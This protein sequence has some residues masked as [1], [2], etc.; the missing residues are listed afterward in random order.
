M[1]RNFKV[2]AVAGGPYSREELEDVY[3][4]QEYS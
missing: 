2:W 3:Y 1:K 4:E